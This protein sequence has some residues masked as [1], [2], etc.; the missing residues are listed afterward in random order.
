MTLVVAVGT[1]V[2]LVMVPVPPT[3]L[4]IQMGAFVQVPFLNVSVIVG[5]AP[6]PE[7]LAVT[8]ICQPW[9]VPVTAVTAAVLPQPPDNA[10]SPAISAVPAVHFNLRSDRSPFARKTLVPVPESD[11]KVEFILAK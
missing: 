1:S 7:P 6:I 3:I 5:L 10:K 2:R 8:V 9:S 11:R 4:E